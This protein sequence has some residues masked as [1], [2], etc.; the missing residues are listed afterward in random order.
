MDAPEELWRSPGFLC[1]CFAP[2]SVVKCGEQWDNEQMFERQDCQVGVKWSRPTKIQQVPRDSVAFTADSTNCCARQNFI[3]TLSHDQLWRL[4]NEP[5]PRH[6]RTA[7]QKPS[8][9][10][11]DG[12][13][14]DRSLRASITSETANV[15]D[16]ARLSKLKKKK[17]KKYI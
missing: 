7:N 3:G 1:S 13:S 2:L 5:T 17:K 9:E 12:R 14:V 16:A 8:L 15:G 10:A 11:A 4:L 6:S